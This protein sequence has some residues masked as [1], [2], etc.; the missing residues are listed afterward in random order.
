M[1]KKK[2]GISLGGLFKERIKTLLF[3]AAAACAFASNCAQKLLKQHKKQESIKVI[4]RIIGYCYMGEREI[5][6]LVTGRET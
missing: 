5:G 4:S 2:R 6:D 3:S 1:L